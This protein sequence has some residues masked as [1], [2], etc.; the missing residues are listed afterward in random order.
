M[1]YGRTL[2]PHEETYVNRASQ[3]IAQLGAELAEEIDRNDVVYAKSQLS[4]EL[5]YTIEVLNFSALQWTQL[6]IDTMIDFYTQVGDLAQFSTCQINSSRL[7]ILPGTSCAT[8]EMLTTMRDEIIRY[9]DASDS[10]LLELIQTVEGD[11]IARDD[12][13]WAYVLALETGTPVLEA[14]LT[15]QQDIGGIVKEEVYVAGTKLEDIWREGLLNLTPEIADFAVTGAL[16]ISLVGNLSVSSFN[17]VPTNVKGQLLLSDNRGVLVDVPVSGSS[18]IPG[19]P[20]DYTIAVGEQLVWTL[21]A[22]NIEQTFTAQGAYYSLAGS[23]EAADD[24]PVIVT[25]AMLSAAEASGLKELVD[26]SQEIEFTINTPNT[27]QGWIAVESAQS[28]QDYLKWFVSEV[29]SGAIEIGEFI[30]P[31]YNVAYNGRTYRIYSWGYRSPLSE[32]LK[33]HR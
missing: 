2:A 12:A 25:S 27:Y 29:N 20:L 24:I 17:W 22:D 9:V 15:S 26:S 4:V 7:Y 11:S 14:D 16:P 5:Q 30:I 6:E 13:I 33:L 23:N 31:P 32:P 3:R 21:K 8:I 18:Y 28:G 19:T 10:Y 1:Y